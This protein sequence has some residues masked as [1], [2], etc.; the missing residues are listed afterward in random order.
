MGRQ[1]RWHRRRA[2]HT[3]FGEYNMRND[4]W[5]QEREMYGTNEGDKNPKNIIKNHRNLLRDKTQSSGN[6]NMI[7]V[8]WRVNIAL[9]RNVFNCNLTKSGA[10]VEGWWRRCEQK[11]CWQM[12]FSA[13][14]RAIPSEVKKLLRPSSLLCHNIQKREHRES[15]KFKRVH[16][17]GL[18][19]NRVRKV[20]IEWQK[21]FFCV[22]P[23][24]LQGVNLA[25]CRVSSYSDRSDSKFAVWVSSG[26]HAEQSPS[27]VS[28]SL[29]L[30]VS[31]FL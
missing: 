25:R 7:I 20:S 11:K 21:R 12:Q 29:S 19:L 30:L 26:Y 4:K 3:A 10:R 22:S 5:E 27:V 16:W 24:R 17:I 31:V 1:H 23:A 2:A 6:L 8:F 14:R 18:E 15:L 9:G 28:L 13:K